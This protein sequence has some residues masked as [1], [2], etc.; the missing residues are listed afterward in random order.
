M[1]VRLRGH[2]SGTL[3]R[4]RALRDPAE[5]FPHHARFTRRSVCCGFVQTGVGSLHKADMEVA[6]LIRDPHCRILI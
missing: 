1:L 6:P 2:H 5:P 4:S 3:E